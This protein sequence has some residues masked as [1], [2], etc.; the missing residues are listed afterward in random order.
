LAGL[1]TIGLQQRPAWDLLTKVA[2]DC[3]PDLRR[4]VLEYLIVTDDKVKTEEIATRLGYPTQ[5]TRRTL[6]DLAAHQIVI[7][8]KGQAD[9]WNLSDWAWNRY[10]FAVLEE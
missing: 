9:M 4:K 1:E 2:L 8:H 5:T 10:K 3:M 7:R 6:E